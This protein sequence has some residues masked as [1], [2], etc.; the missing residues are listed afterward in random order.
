M[1]E[2]FTNLKEHPEWKSL[3]KYLDGKR[4]EFLIKL[5]KTNP[6]DTNSMAGYQEKIKLLDL[7][8]SKVNNN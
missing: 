6:S 4:R 8:V 7:I 3:E 1:S 5:V 2:D